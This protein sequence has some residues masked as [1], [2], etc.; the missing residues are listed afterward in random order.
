M[1]YPYLSDVLNQIFGTQWHIPIAM[2]GSFVAIAIVVGTWI[3]KLE[4]KRFEG[5]GLLPKANVSTGVYVPT[6][7]ILSDLAMVTAI[8]GIIGARVFHILEYPSEFLA[9][10]TAF[11]K[12]VVAST[13]KFMPLSLAAHP[14]VPDSN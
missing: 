6:H 8:A 3:A 12:L 11:F 2:F 5:L 4:V 9:N 14:R 1:S 10:P 13:V 7:K